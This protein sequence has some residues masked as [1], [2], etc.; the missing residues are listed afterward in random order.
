MGPRLTRA[1]H[2]L[3]GESALLETQWRDPGRCGVVIVF[4]ETAGR[5][6]AGEQDAATGLWVW[7]QEADSSRHDG[8]TT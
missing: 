1:C 3:L 4:I 6:V 8:V 2:K 5:R 7:I